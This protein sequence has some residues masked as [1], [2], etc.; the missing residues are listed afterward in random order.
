MTKLPS[1]GTGVP[2]GRTGGTKTTKLPSGGTENG[3]PDSTIG[4]GG[5]AGPG[6]AARFYLRVGRERGGTRRGR[7]GD[8]KGTKLP[9][10]G[11]ENGQPASTFGWDGRGGTGGK[12]D[13]E[14]SFGRDE[15][16]GREELP[17]GGTRRGRTR[18]RTET[19]PGRH[20]SS[21]ARSTT[22]PYPSYRDCTFALLHWINGASTVYRTLAVR[23]PETRSALSRS[24]RGR[25][26]LRPHHR[27]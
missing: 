11:T 16:A 19:E 8:E 2:S 21:P 10:G 4:T 20:P 3:Q 12:E 1:G 27:V 9:S 7:E 5:T 17:S 22:A 18:T 14:T 26:D 24:R 15:K 25:S 6:R 23:A 13:D